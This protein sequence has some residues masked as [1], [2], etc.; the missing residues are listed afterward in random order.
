[1]NFFLVVQGEDNLSRLVKMINWGIH[2]EETVSNK[3][4]K[5]HEGPEL[6]FPAV[7]CALIVFLGP[8]AEV[9]AK[10]DQVGYA[11]VLGFGSVGS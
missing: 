1:M 9:E 7:A 4:Q 3:E 10:L 6:D 2:G 11:V 5:V 8:E